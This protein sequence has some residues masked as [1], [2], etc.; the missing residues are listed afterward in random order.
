MKQTLFFLLQTVTLYTS[1]Q[2]DLKEKFKIFSVNSQKLGKVEFCTFTSTIEKK[3]PLLIFIHGSGN[4]PTFS[5]QKDLKTYAWKGFLEIEKYKDQFH[6][7]CVNKPG[8]PLFDTVQKNPVNFQTSYPLNQEFTNR[9]SLEWRAEAASLIINEAV[10]KLAVDQSKVLVI[11][12]S[13][14]GQVAPKVAVINKKVTHVVLLNSNALN[15]LYDFVLQERLAAFKGEQSFEQTQTNIDS[16]FADY[17]RIFAQPDSRTKTWNEETYFRWAS[18]SDETPLEN[19][20]KLKI[21][22]YVV[23]GGKDLWGSF[24][25]NTDYV[26]IDFLR[27]NKTNLTYRVFPNANHFLQDEITENGKTKTVDLKPAIFE[28]IIKWAEK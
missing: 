6:V 27:H 14:G 5:Y 3:K 24:I 25:M 19:M 9:Y 2:T 12:H 21:P 20:L 10:K 7:I 15:H 13:Q 11:G 1:G 8:I 18:F 16:L 28:A 26:Q 17:K 4:E 23:A 22:I